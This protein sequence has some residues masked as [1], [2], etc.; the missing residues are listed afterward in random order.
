VIEATELPELASECLDWERCILMGFYSR[1][2]A[3][4]VAKFYQEAAKKRYEHIGNRIN[5]TLQSGE[6]AILFIREGHEVQFAKDIEVFSV[7][8][9]ALNDIH[10]WLRDHSGDEKKSGEKT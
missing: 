4:L 1:K 10:R 5:E 9:P 6:A 3:E 8:P 7:A 2:A